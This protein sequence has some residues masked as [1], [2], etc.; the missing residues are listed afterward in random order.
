MKSLLLFLSLIALFV[1]YQT[2]HLGFRGNFLPNYSSI[3]ITVVISAHRG[4]ES[5]HTRLLFPTSCLNA[6]LIYALPYATSPTL[7]GHKFYVKILQG[8]G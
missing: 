2:D 4:F 3:I 1:P 5:F 6:Y 7:I 8:N